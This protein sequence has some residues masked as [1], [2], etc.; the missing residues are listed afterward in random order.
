MNRHETREQIFIFLFESTFGDREIDEIIESAQLARD[1][2]VNDYCRKVF[3][4]VR[5]KQ[6]EIDKHIEENIKNWSKDRLSRTTIS[7]LRL[8]IYEILFEEGLPSSVSINEAVEIAKKYST[9]KDASYINGV[10][11]SINRKIDDISKESV[12]EQA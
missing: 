2:K 9:Q 12:A 3:K 10:L 4:G 7:I 5:D 8:A 6:E 11:G 1:V